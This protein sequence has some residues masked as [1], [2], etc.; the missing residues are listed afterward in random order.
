MIS[1]G[2]FFLKFWLVLV[3]LINWLL[4]S[5]CM[6]TYIVLSFGCMIFF[7]FPNVLIKTGYFNTEFLSLRFINTIQYGAKLLDKYTGKSQIS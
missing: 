3:A 4:K 1:F 6:L 2:V 5:K 7:L